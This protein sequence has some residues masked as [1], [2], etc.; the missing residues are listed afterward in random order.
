M[1]SAA[2]RKT[3]RQRS[4][5]GTAGPG[6]STEPLPAA[7]RDR[8][9][10]SLGV[11][12][13]T[14]RM[15]RGAAANRLTDSLGAR[16]VTWGQNIALAR[17]ATE[18][19]LA[20]ELVHAAQ[21]R[22]GGKALDGTSNPEDSAERQARALAPAVAV[23][24]PVGAPL[25]RPSAS[26]QLDE[27][28]DGGLPGPLAAPERDPETGWSFDPYGEDV[29]GLGNVGLLAK[30]ATTRD[31]L[32]SHSIVE[33]DY[34]AMLILRD[35]LDTE[36][37][38]RIDLGHLWLEGEEG[39]SQ[40]LYRLMPGVNGAI[41]LVQVEN[42]ALI[43]S[44]PVDLGG[45]PIM[46]AAQFAAWK[47]GLGLPEM[48]VAEYLD[49]TK[50]VSAGTP[51]TPGEMVNP[52]AAPTFGPVQTGPGDV[53]LPG[54]VSLAGQRY[55]D[56]ANSFGNQSGAGRTGMISEA[57]FGSGPGALFG[58]GATNRNATQPNHPLTDFATRIGPFDD[59]SVKTRVPGS[60]NY[61]SPNRIDRFANYLSG[62]AQLQAMD[63]T[64]TN[65]DAFMALHGNGRT[66]AQ[67]R[68]GLGMAIDASDLA[69]YRALLSDPQF[70]EP[71]ASG[72]TSAEPNYRR[73]PIATIFDGILRDRP[74]ELGDGGPP[75]R[76]VAE[77]DAA[78]AANRIGVMQ[79]DAYLRGAGLD[80]SA[81]VISNPDFGSAQASNF[82]TGFQGLHPSLRPEPPPRVDTFSAARRENTA[83]ADSAS[84][85]E[86]F[87]AYLSNQAAMHASGGS[88]LLI[89]Q[90]DVT[91]YQS[92][93]R[94]P[95]GRE[96]TPT[97]R[98]SPK[99][100]FAREPVRQVYDSV[101][102][103]LPADQAIRS[104][105]GES[106]STIKAINDARDV[107]R[108]SAREH[109]E[110]IARI[111]RIAARSVAADT[112]EMHA[113]DRSRQADYA[114]ARARANQYI[115]ANNSPEYMQSVAHGGG[116]SGDFRAARTNA[117]RSAKLGGAFGFGSSLW[118]NRDANW[119]DPAVWQ[120]AALS[121]TRDA[122]RGGVTT[123][124]E[125][126]AKSRAS[127]YLLRE[128][129]EVGTTRA[130]MTRGAARFV[131][132]GVVDA[133]F[134]IGDIV[135]SDRPVS[136]GEAT[137]RVGRAVVIGAGS[138]LIGTAAAGAVAGSVVPGVG[139]AIGFVVGLAAGLLLGALIPSW[140]DFDGPSDPYNGDIPMFRSDYERA[141]RDGRLNCMGVGHHRK[142]H[143][144][145]EHNFGF[146]A[147]GTRGSFFQDF[148]RTD[149]GA[150]LDQ[151]F[152]G[153]MSEADRAML[154]QWLE[155]SRDAGTAP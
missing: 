95:F 141:A 64:A 44:G 42:Y 96:E 16:A 139:T 54:G 70:H 115:N 62:Q 9:E 103:A 129:L 67:V 145:E 33:L 127:N 76:S 73:S 123:T 90:G 46:N 105:A 88:T 135:T 83:R 82:M 131:P 59:V 140:D 93:L 121:G 113:A 136:G 28:A 130:L 110:L 60:A 2:P 37:N 107:G 58:F 51:L 41:D 100:N 84:R 108:L 50:T 49:S 36:R 34:E 12:L 85:I 94:D 78:L 92:L 151:R 154:V 55:I 114:G 14:V 99:R 39:T 13:S 43:D 98:A 11:P 18:V 30:I 24:E 19:T 47:A 144:I 75:L 125:T 91:P 109:Y 126:V 35:R 45:Q 31:W 72:G 124:L 142:V 87:D 122:V 153:Q 77:I 6:S 79:A 23:G 116:W 7:T 86:Q 1:S 68:A 111:G 15:H 102:A 112:P 52:L 17:D 20:H 4:P 155:S 132:G 61:A 25:Q 38:Y 150:P 117:G 138:T 5:D 71:T 32:A 66:P 26:V 128:G 152:R 120:D 106:F 118:R 146:D 21:N 137:Y 147:P 101:L 134:E 3:R 8:A 53:H 56:I 57:Y 48:S 149:G 27:R 63:P 133:A 81:Q 10:R 80:A 40:L 143:I 148:P 65:F 97:G 89:P 119:S 74:I 104:R 22:R 69:D 29:V